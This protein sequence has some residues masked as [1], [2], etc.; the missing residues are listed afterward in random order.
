MALIK[1]ILKGAST[2][3]HHAKRN[4][5][6]RS[7]QTLLMEVPDLEMEKGNAT[8]FS[9]P[10]EGTSDNQDSQ[11]GFHMEKLKVECF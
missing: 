7:S 4:L 1:Y 2:G 5:T 10:E 6:A 8:P 11:P 9:F 3:H